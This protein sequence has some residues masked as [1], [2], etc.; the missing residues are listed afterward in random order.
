MSDNPAAD[1]LA[2]ANAKKEKA[3]A[4]KKEAVD[5]FKDLSKK[6]NVASEKANSNPTVENH[7]AA[8]TANKAA[9]DQGRHV[10]LNHSVVNTM[11][12]KADHHRLVASIHENAAKELAKSPEQKESEAKQKQEEETKRAA[13]HK[14]YSA[15]DTAKSHMENARLSAS[16]GKFAA[17]AESSRKAIGAFKEA[18]NHYIDAK[19]ATG[20]RVMER[21]AKEASEGAG[22]DWDESKHPR[23][24]NGKFT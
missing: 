18:H 15:E 6:A 12:D 11:H 14:A 7:Q 4:A 3:K 13:S 23:D 9:A 24:D 17:A 20:A 5:K 22:E 10:Y 8:A 2:K 21:K 1:I 16:A 19:D